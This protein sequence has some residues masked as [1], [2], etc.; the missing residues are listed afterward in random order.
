MSTLLDE[1]ETVSPDDKIER[2]GD[3]EQLVRK[4]VA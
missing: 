4:L 2:G 3:D 1:Q